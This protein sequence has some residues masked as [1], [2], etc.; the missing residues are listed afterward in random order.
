MKI[1]QLKYFLKIA[2]LGSIS[3]ASRQL[4]I[5]QPA[6]SHHMSALET[7]LKVNLFARSVKGVQ[8]TPAGEKLVHHANLILRQIENARTDLISD[9]ISPRGEIR[10]VIDSSKAYSL[11]P[12]LVTETAKRFPDIQLT[13]YE[14]MSP[15]AGQHIT[16]GKVDLALVPNAADLSGVI[17][18]PV[19][20]ESMFLVGKNILNDKTEQDKNNPTIPFKSLSKYPLVCPSRLHNI[21][22]HIEQSALEANRPLNIRYEQNTAQELRSFINSGIAFAIIP[23]DVMAP[24]LSQGELQALKIVQPSIDRIHSVVVR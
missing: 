8:L 23:R 24:E 13:V 12:M 1:I 14:A 22:K 3:A 18:L 2:E 5:A 17:A 4:F 11:L 21:R 16:E 10:L 15:V 9:E 6:L 20:R 19:Y 7:D